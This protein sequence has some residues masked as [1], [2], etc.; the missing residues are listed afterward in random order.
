MKDGK[1]QFGTQEDCDKFFQKAKR[2]SGSTQNKRK[3]KEATDD[4]IDKLKAKIKRL[5]RANDGLMRKYMKLQ[6]NYD[7]LY[8][9]YKS[10]KENTVY[11]PNIYDDER[12]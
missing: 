12:K 4:C 11:K 5:E 1:L 9:A 7:C 3:P 6:E 10:L 2:A 8:D